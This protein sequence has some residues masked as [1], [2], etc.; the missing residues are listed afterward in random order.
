MNQQAGS[1]PND[2]YGEMLRAWTAMASVALPRADATDPFLGLFAQAHLAS[3]A[4]GMRCWSRWAQ[5]WAEYRQAAMPAAAPRADDGEALG[6]AVD[7]ARAHLRRLGE[8]ALDEARLLDTQM[9][10]LS[11]QL[12][13]VVEDPAAPGAPRRRARAKP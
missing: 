4:A 2:P 3:A 1:F 12:R 5:S 9:Q 10:A 13:T 11:E 8:I 7:E 6:R